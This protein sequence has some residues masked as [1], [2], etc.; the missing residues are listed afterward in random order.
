VGDKVV[1]QL[2]KSVT[3]KLE[4]TVARQIQLQFHTS[5]KQILQVCIILKFVLIDG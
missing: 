1:N 3:A 4:A 5:V 2:D